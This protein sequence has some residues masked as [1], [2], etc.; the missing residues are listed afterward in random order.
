MASPCT[1]CQVEFQHLAVLASRTMGHEQFRATCYLVV[2]CN[3][4][5]K[6]MD[7]QW[8]TM[9]NKWV[10]KYSDKVNNRLMS[11]EENKQF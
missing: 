7:K 10:N 3:K 9:D 5:V 4:M 11:K 6:V 8:V 2:S 1:C